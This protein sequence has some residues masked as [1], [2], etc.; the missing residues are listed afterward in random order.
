MLHVP[1]YYRDD[2]EYANKRLSSTYVLTTDKKLM[3]VN[4]IG[5]QI[6]PK[7]NKSQLF[8]SGIKIGFEDKLKNDSPNYGLPTVLVNVS[9]LNLAPLTLGY[10]YSARDQRAVYLSRYPM[11]QIYK[12]GLHTNAISFSLGSKHSLTPDELLSPVFNVYPSIR[13]AYELAV[14]R[15]SVVP[16][17]RDFAIEHKGSIEYRGRDIV[18]KIEFADKKVVPVLDPKFAYLQQHLDWSL[19]DKRT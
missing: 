12:Q 5:E 10:I 3:L 6:D 19:N 4:S 8:A 16:F 2:I 18:G 7:T 13:V 15:G 17:C 1:Y 14:K 11:R 9:E